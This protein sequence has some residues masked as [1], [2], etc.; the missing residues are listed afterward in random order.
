M[1]QSPLDTTPS[2]FQHPGLSKLGK[3][4]LAGWPRKERSAKYF[5]RMTVGSPLPHAKR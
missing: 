4:S 5:P 1:T 2:K 3:T